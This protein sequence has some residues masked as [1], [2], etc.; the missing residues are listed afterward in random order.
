MTDV[1]ERDVT[2]GE[3]AVASLLGLFT[4]AVA[5]AQP[6]EDV[7]EV[8]RDKAGECGCEQCIEYLG[9]DEVLAGA[10]NRPAAVLP[11]GE[12]KPVPFRSEPFY[13][14]M[15]DSLVDLMFGTETTTTTTVEVEGDGLAELCATSDGCPLEAEGL[16]CGCELGDGYSLAEYE[17][18]A[19]SSAIF[20]LDDRTKAL[21]YLIPG[22][23]AEAG[24]VAG[25][26]AKFVR[27]HD[28]YHFFRQGVAD[29]SL[30]WVLP[31]SVRD[32]LLKEA[33]DVLWFVAVLSRVL[34]SSLAD[35]AWANAEKLS[36]RK[37][38]NVLA[39]SGDN[40]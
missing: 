32:D 10:G 22:L 6:G 4:A 17:E 7:L 34:G 16:M 2:G 31:D 12:A 11:D 19:A 40:R 38:R 14:T 36:D 24:E 35:V 33:G 15:P 30:D 20:D 27:D 5:E 37:R 21:S 18:Q 29:D 28:D 3:M 1:V 9:V 13:V 25:K 23:A 8:V 39:G 26:F